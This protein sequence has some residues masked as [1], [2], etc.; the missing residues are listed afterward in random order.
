MRSGV[1]TSRETE[2][3]AARRPALL[4]MVGAAITLVAAGCMYLLW[5]VNEDRMG[6][7][8]TTQSLR[9]ETAISSMACGR[10]GISSRHSKL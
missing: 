9:T 10:A 4:W 7:L 2:R 1:L 5:L 8:T 6:S 3:M